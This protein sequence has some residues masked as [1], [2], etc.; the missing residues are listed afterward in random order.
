MNDQIMISPIDARHVSD[1]SLEAAETYVRA[2]QRRLSED[3]AAGLAALDDI[4]R[5]GSLPDPALDGRYRG[6]IVA[7]DVAPGLNQMTAALANLGDPWR[8]K[9][10]Y[11]A[12]NR[13]E[14]LVATT[15][16]WPARLLWPF[17]ARYRREGA[18][19]RAF[20]FRTAAGPSLRDPDV[21]VLKLDYD[22]PANPRLALSI[23]RILD[24]VVKVAD[25]YY[26]GRAYVH[27]YWGSWSVAAYFALRPDE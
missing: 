6:E 15:A 21:R 16:T 8:G 18:M 25:G 2:A 4:F 20:P 10:F 14:N 7:I 24:E 27:W 26:L 22:I 9:V 11:A 1:V 17:Y 5:C 12:A 3:R 19:S 13:G 23:R